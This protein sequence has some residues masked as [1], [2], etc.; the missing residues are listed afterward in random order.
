MAI[1]PPGGI[2][3]SA[4]FMARGATALLIAYWDAIANR[5]TIMEDYA[6]KHAY[7]LRTIALPTYAHQQI[8]NHEKA[9]RIMNDDELYNRLDTA[10]T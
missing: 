5:S 3:F 1:V 10:G 6:F 7:A 4:M 9:R 2:S 8:V